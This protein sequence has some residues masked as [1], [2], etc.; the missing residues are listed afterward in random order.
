VADIDAVREALGYET[1]DL[2]AISYGTELAR[3]TMASHP[4]HVRRV[5]LI[6]APATDFRTPLTH[7]MHAQRA[8]DLLFHEC[9]VDD[10]C[11]GAFPELRIDWQRALARVDE[12]VQVPFGDPAREITIHP[13]AFREALRGLFGTATGR[14]QIPLLVHHAARGD[15][16]PF[17]ARL[18]ADSSMFSEGLYLSIACSEGTSRIDPADI[19]AFTTGTFLGTYRVDQQMRA[20]SVWPRAEVPESL[21]ESVTTDHPT[22]LVSGEIDATT[23]PEASRELCS[24]LPNCQL[25]VIP[26]MG[27]VPFDLDAWTDGACLESLMIDFFELADPRAVDTSCLSGMVP[28]TFATGGG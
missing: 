10:G 11:R 7:A 17:L 2:F 5:L 21:F 24:H 15:F 25:L 13:G 3:A 4:D 14:R 16:A 9:Q 27:H 8:L 22:L 19:A 28:P 1:I 12:G 6:G 18:P 23:P 20:C 26:A